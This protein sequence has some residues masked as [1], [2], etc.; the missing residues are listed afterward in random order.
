[1]ARI[2]RSGNGSFVGKSITVSLTREMRAFDRLPPELREAFRQTASDISVSGLTEHIARDGTAKIA[3][4]IRKYDRLIEQGMSRADCRAWFERRY[5]GRSLPKSAC[6]GCPFR[7]NDEWRRMREQAPAD[8]A[9]AVTVDA[10]IREPGRGLRS[11][12]YIH[13]SRKPLET[14]I[15]APDGSRDLISDCS[16]G[17]C[18]T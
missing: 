18:F 13:E 9:D 14:A 6:I 2:T 5:P 11:R 3:D 7:R 12:Q 17:V 4:F 8:F 10:A 15:D 16:T 1:M